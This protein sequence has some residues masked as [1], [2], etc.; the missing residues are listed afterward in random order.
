MN[1]AGN[2]PNP[3][4][5]PNPNMIPNPHTPTPTTGVPP[6]TE[7]GPPPYHE[8]IKLIPMTAEQSSRY[9]RG[10]LPYVCLRTL[11]LVP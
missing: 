3:N 5:N 9:D 11:L 2:N 7:A 1:N 8:N 10:P 6:P 4:P